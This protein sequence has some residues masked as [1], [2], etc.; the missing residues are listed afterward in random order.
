MRP[1]CGVA[2]SH[3]EESE[4]EELVLDASNDKKLNSRIVND[5]ETCPHLCFGRLAIMNMG[6]RICIIGTQSVPSV[7]VGK[8][9]ALAEVLALG[10]SETPLLLAV[11]MVSARENYVRVEMTPVER[12]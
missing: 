3:K 10:R 7:N 5:C 8:R 12:I 2:R 9:F 1:S 4:E 6:V 11:W